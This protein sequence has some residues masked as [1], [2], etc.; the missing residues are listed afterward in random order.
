MIVHEKMVL[1]RE[2]AREIAAERRRDVEIEN[3]TKEN[4]VHAYSIFCLTIDALKK[5]L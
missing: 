3:F 4:T 2:G 5:Q 1:T